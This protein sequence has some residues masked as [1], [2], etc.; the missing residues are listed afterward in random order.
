MAAVAGLA[1]IGIA[2]IHQ[3]LTTALADRRP[4][5]WLIP[6]ALAVPVPAVALFIAWLHQ[7]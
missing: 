6:A 5:W 2:A 4:A 3:R 1:L 7:I